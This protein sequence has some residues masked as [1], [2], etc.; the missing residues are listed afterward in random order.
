MTPPA[1]SP[2]PASGYPRAGVLF[3]HEVHRVVGGRGRDF[4]RVVRDG[5]RPALAEADGRLLWYFHLAHGTGASYTVV[6][7]T[8]FAAAQA[9]HD[10]ALRM[11]RGDLRDLA[12]ELDRFR[13]H[14]TGK[15]LVPTPWSPRQEVDFAEVDAAPPEH[16]PSLYMEDTGWPFHGRLEDYTRALGEWYEPMTRAGR[17]IQVEAFLQ[18][19][20]GAGRRPE[21]VLLQKLGDQSQLLRLLTHEEPESYPEDSW[22]TRALT[23]RDQWGSRLLRTAPWSPLW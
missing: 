18:P 13:H 14:V 15:L 21:V 5:L 17:L 23:L 2:A 3:L 11:L 8:G 7:V 9:W 19:A 6:T 22:M 20:Y 12:T 16:E 10:T 4:E 1:P